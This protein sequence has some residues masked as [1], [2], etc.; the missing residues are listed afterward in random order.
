MCLFILGLSEALITLDSLGSFKLF[1]FRSS[2]HKNPKTKNHLF[3]LPLFQC[4]LLPL[5][6]SLCTLFPALF[7]KIRLHFM[8][9]S[10][11]KC[12]IKSKG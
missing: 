12:Q 5:D 9:T 3:L 7:T 10:I 4:V 2:S 11:S 8:E 6:T 1:T